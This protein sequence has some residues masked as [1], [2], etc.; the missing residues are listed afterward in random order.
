MLFK[1]K[2]IRRLIWGLLGLV[3]TI[4]AYGLFQLNDPV[5]IASIS[6]SAQPLL[7]EGSAL[8]VA[9][10]AD[11][12]ATAYA[13]AKLNRVEGIEDTLTVISLPFNQD[14]PVVATVPVPNSV[15][16]WPQ[17]IA[18]SP[19]GTKA[20]VAE[21]R[22]TP[23]P[24]VQQL[25][26]I[27]E[28]PDGSRIT[29]VDIEN[30][31]QPTIVES[32]EVGRNPRHVAISPDGKFL[33]IDLDEPGRELLLVRLNSDGTLGDR[34]YFPITDA[35]GNP[36]EVNSS[37]W[38]PSSRFLALNLNNHSVAFYEVS[39][40]ETSVEINPYG[41]PI[42][43]GNHLSCGQFTPDGQTY[44]ISDLK[45]STKPLR[46][47]NYLMNPRGELVAIQFN[48]AGAQ[49]KIVSRAEVGLS[50][51][52]FDVS[53]DGSLVVTVN[54]RRTYLSAFPP[55]WR[56]KSHSSLS[57]V[58]LDRETGT[59]TTLEEYGF[60]GLLPEDAVFDASGNFLAALIYNYRE[61]S[62][63]TGAVEFWRVVREGQPSLERTG[64]KLDVVRGAHVG[65]LVR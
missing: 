8:L 10:D 46:V 60:E 55:V 14:K 18:T 9:S 31:T 52:G 19:D 44:L 42:E 62:P 56:G 3:A 49:P 38:H 34:S 33:A 47:L 36:A 45:W 40:D 4:A 50:P 57:I 22:G 51:E 25:D 17:I 58:Q 48:D 5:S 26:T 13:D 1:S 24:G 21:V 7:F 41:E 59:L 32:V 37:N 27:E 11:M 28:M 53:P 63:E 20:Y 23:P 65:S 54:M 12:V 35:T 2:V 61:T 30:P 29:V 16:S 43:V 15:M 64:L 39:A 6:Q